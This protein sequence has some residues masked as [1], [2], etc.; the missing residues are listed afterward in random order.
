MV[1]TA[2]ILRDIMY[3]SGV[4]CGEGGH[5]AGGG[6]RGNKMLWTSPAT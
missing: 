2:E 4:G 6:E 5:G 3:R 1:M